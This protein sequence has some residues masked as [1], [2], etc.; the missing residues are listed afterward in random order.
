MKPVQSFYVDGRACVRVGNDV[1]KWFLVNVALRQGYVMSP[2]LFNVCVDSVVQEVN[3]KVLS[4]GLD[5]LKATG[6]R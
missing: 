2:R 1:S 5:L 6:L 3:V 4:K